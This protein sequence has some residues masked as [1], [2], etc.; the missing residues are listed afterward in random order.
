[1]G[2]VNSVSI[3]QHVH[4]NIVRWSATACSDGIGGEQELRK[5]KGIPSSESLY[6]VYLDNFD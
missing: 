4:R 1:M 2:F 5:D 6:R 3:A